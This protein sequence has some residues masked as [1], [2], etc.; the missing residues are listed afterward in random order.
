MWYTYTMKYYSA[1]HTHT[2][3]KE[4]PVFWD[5]MDEILGH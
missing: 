3:T 4:N 2:H 1:T 5:D